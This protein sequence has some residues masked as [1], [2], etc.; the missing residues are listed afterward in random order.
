VR[1]PIHRRWT[2]P[3][4]HRIKVPNAA[5]REGGRAHFRTSLSAVEFIPN[6]NVT[7]DYNSTDLPDNV[8]VPLRDDPRLLEAL[9]LFSEKTALMNSVPGIDVS[10]PQDVARKVAKIGMRADTLIAE[11][12]QPPVP[13]YGLSFD[14]GA[15]SKREKI[16]RN[17]PCPSG[18][19]KKFKKCC[20]ST[21]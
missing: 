3:A 10:L 2:P 13:G 4:S 18:G 17:D 5:N 9:K 8:R 14:A 16:G 11:V 6:D 20:G 15:E 1:P 21:A 12:S 19:G 7:Y